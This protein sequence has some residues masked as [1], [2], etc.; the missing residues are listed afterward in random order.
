MFIVQLT[1]E[2]FRKIIRE[3][4]SADRDQHKPEK[5]IRDVKYLTR[6]QTAALLH[7]SLVTLK[8]YDRLNL[9]KAKKIGGRVLYDYEK[10][11]T[12]IS[13]KRLPSKIS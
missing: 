2:E 11:I 7:V 12:A 8:K 4:I 3:E 1:V 5:A 6:K 9:L 13:E 10:V